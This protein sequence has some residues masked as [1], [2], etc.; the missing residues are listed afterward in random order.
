MVN[1]MED[2]RIFTHSQKYPYRFQSKSLAP[3]K[4]GNG[5]AR[6][7]VEP[8]VYIPG[9]GWDI[10]D[11]NVKGNEFI[12]GLIK[13]I[14]SKEFAGVEH[15]GHSSTV[16]RANLEKLWGYRIDELWGEDEK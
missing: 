5:K 3:L 10:I 8:M 13:Y 14:R 6:F 4:G 7:S 11:V 12:I 2:E 15:T 1:N 16:M 9:A